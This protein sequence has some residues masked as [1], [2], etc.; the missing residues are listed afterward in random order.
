M[1]TDHD[2]PAEPGFYFDAAGNL[3]E[4]VEPP[5]GKPYVH[6]CCEQTFEEVCH[7]IDEADT[8]T[9]E[10]LVAGRDLANSQVAT[11]LRFLREYGLIEECYPRRNRRTEV[12][13]FLSAM[14]CWHAVR[15]PEAAAG[16]TTA[17]LE[18]RKLAIARRAIARAVGRVLGPRGEPEALIPQ[19]PA[20]LASELDVVTVSPQGRCWRSRPT[21][22]S[23][24]WPEGWVHPEDRS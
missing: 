9:L 17:R 16:G 13:I 21:K 3:A 2:Q 5:R 12:S 6:R 15:D 18:P 22:P 7:L 19:R 8:F 11:A 4:Y 24:P 10:E 14:T 20:P 1:T 23:R